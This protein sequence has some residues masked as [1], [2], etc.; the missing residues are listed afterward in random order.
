VH[1]DAAAVYPVQVNTRVS[2]RLRKNSV[3]VNQWKVTL[4]H[5]GRGISPP[6]PPP[7]PGAPPPRLIRRVRRFPLPFSR[8]LRMF[9]H[10]IEFLVEAGVGLTS[11]QGSDPVL[12]VTFSGDG[13]K[14][15]GDQITVPIG[16][17]GEYFTQASIN[18]LG[19]LR[20]GVC[21]VVF[22]DPCFLALLDC[23]VDV[24]EGTN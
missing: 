9:F 21:E 7:P 11:G 19:A 6:P 17:I 3:N 16:K 23:F 1:A 4:L 5:Y 2:A 14:T 13:G 12:M 18:Q 15:W 22:T 10:R 8:N 24:E 20:N